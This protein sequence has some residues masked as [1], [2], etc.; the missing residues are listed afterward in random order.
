MK[1]RNY[2]FTSFK[3]SL[4]PDLTRI[5]YICWGEEKCPET[6]KDHL[7]GYV[8][9]KN[10]QRLDGAKRF[11][12]DEAA[13]L[14]KRK[15]T[16]DQAREYCRKSGGTFIEHGE[17]EIHQGKRTDLEEALTENEKIGDFMDN[18]P[19]LYCQFRSGVKDLYARKLQKEQ[20]ETR[21]VEV[22]VLYGYAGRGKTEAAIKVA[23]RLEKEWFMLSPEKDLWFDGYD[24][25]E[26]LIIDDFK[27]QIP[28]ATLNRILDK[29]PYRCP[30]KGSF[31]WAKWTDVI[32]TSNWEP[33]QWYSVGSG[34]N[35]EAL[36]R[37][38][39]FIQER[40][41]DHKKI[42]WRDYDLD[43]T[44]GAIVVQDQHLVEDDGWAPLNEEQKE[45]EV[46]EK[47]ED[48][49]NENEENVIGGEP[50]PLKRQN[51][52]TYV[53]YDDFVFDDD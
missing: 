17:W 23:T 6:G 10:S 36:D 29:Y 15:G 19:K 20:P 40:T 53:D 16:R 4:D 52:K 8:E 9:F 14:E 33:K 22:M 41:K 32:I 13:H 25:Q 50:P 5:R 39:H 18:C 49:K 38:L 28:P 1:S 3:A 12:G 7:Q 24:G 51:C 30:V 42:T 11:I 45:E 44:T 35:W 47:N 26:V 37:R 27:G 31:T 21:Q 34:A 2:C 43:E 46:K 48:E